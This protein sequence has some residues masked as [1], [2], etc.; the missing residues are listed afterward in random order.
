MADITFQDVV[1]SENLIGLQF[2]QAEKDSMLTNL[3]NYREEYGELRKSKLENAT[4]P[5]L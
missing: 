1:G 2:S 4:K 5:S 3:E